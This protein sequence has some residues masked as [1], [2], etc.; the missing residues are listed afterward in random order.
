[1]SFPGPPDGSGIRPGLVPSTTCGGFPRAPD[2]MTCAEGWPT[3]APRGPEGHCS[4][5]ARQEP[6]WRA[7]LRGAFLDHGTAPPRRHEA[8]QGETGVDPEESQDIKALQKDPE[9]F[10]K[11]L[12]Q[13]Q[14]TLGY[15]QT[16]VGLTL[17]V[18][19]GNVFS[20]RTTCQ[21]EAL[22]LSFNEHVQAAASAAEV[23]GEK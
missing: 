23:G 3:G 14:I 4:L 16:N 20:Q 6:G 13:K 9:Q 18:L 8:G 7:T 19:F 1:M 5:R 17:G 2:P 11:L 21:F 15:T 22:Q 12:K 10:A